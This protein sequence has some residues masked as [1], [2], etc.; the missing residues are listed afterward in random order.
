VETSQAREASLAQVKAAAS[1]RTPKCARRGCEVRG[2]TDEVMGSTKPKARPPERCVRGRT[3]LGGE[4]IFDSLHIF[5]AS[6][7]NIRILHDANSLQKRG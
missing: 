1:R 4:K 2:R 6:K 3:E 5:L 7:V